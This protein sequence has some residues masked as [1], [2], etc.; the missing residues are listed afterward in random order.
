MS[1]FLGRSWVLLLDSGPCRDG[2]KPVFMWPV[3]TALRRT[4]CCGSGPASSRPSRCCSGPLVAVMAPCPHGVA[5]DRV[6]RYRPRVLTALRRTMCR[7]NGPASSRRCGGPRTDR[8][9]A[10]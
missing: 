9:A 7:G 4:V 2:M 8:V 10:P 6:S 1:R 3:L 5:A